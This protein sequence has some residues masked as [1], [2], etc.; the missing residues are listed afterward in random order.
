MIT[1][2]FIGS[3]V[4]VSDILEAWGEE[5]FEAHVA[6]MQREYCQRAAIIQVRAHIGYIAVQY[7]PLIK[8]RMVSSCCAA[9]WPR[10]RQQLCCRCWMCQ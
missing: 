8:R 3:Q 5:G 10:R 1:R 4:V 9:A 6:G 2:H 7:S